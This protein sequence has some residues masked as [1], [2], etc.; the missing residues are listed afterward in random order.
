MLH[1]RE[2]TFFG[3]FL[4]THIILFLLACALATGRNNKKM[5]NVTIMKISFF[6]KNLIFIFLFRC[7]ARSHWAQSIKRHD[8][9]Q[10]VPQRLTFMNTHQVVH[11]FIPTMQKQITP[12]G[13]S[14]M[15]N[16]LTE[17]IAAI[18]FSMFLDGVGR[19][20]Y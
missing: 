6:H 17:K 5:V 13:W 12:R 7:Q 1:N 2:G 19:I 14:W 8:F 11:K 3:L 20:L 16:L 4:F 9:S 10:M 18:N 15:S